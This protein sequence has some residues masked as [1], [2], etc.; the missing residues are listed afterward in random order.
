[1]PKTV[2]TK[3]KTIV[4]II[5]VLLVVAI[6]V[7]ASLAYLTDLRKEDAS[8]TVGK[9][10]VSLTGTNLGEKETLY[11]G[12]GYKKEPI[13]TLDKNSEDCYVR[14]KVEFPEELA[15][16][17]KPLDASDAGAG[18]KFEKVSDTLYYYT[19]QD[20]LTNDSGKSGDTAT[21][22]AFEK[23]V[24]M[25]KKPVVPPHMPESVK[26]MTHEQ[27]LYRANQKKMLIE[28]QAIQAGGF[29]SAVDAFKEFK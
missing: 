18:W 6:G 28:V 11:P 2:N 22:V 10:S 27:L 5:S 20:K 9:V 14:I 23:V 8:Y 19:Y 25:S 29:D 7:G 21:T 17:L 4:M 3:Q 15:L 1:M 13:V 24:T 26:E 12:K 16:V